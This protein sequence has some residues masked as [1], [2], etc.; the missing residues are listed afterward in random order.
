MR[1][2]SARLMPSTWLISS[3]LAAIKSLQ[4]A[5]MRQQLLP[6]LGPDARDAFQHRRAARASA[7][8][9]MPGDREAMRLVADLL[10]QMQ[11]GMVGRQ[12]AA[13]A[14]RPEMISCSSPGLRSSPL[15]TPISATLPSPALPALRAPC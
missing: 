12:D 10:D 4:P 5:E 2:A 7:P 3:T 8:V 14:R 6:A 1:S 9:A 11:A 15:A 13:A